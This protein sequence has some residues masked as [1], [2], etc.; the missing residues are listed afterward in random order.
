[1]V[2]CKSLRV[3]LGRFR[4]TERKNEPRMMDGNASTSRELVCCTTVIGALGA[5]L[6]ALARS[7]VVAH[8]GRRGGV[9]S[10][11]SSDRG[12]SIVGYFVIVGAACS[13][14]YLACRRVRFTHK[15]SC[16]SSVVGGRGGAPKFRCAHLFRKI[17]REK[18]EREIHSHRHIY[19]D[20]HP[21]FGP[22]CRMHCSTNC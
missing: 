17:R 12:G 19:T 2:S 3:T 7:S 20:S 13:L 9:M 14:G 5:S 16:R 15:R 21:K 18:R 1:M 11:S 10:T 8:A 4:R 6:C 22:S